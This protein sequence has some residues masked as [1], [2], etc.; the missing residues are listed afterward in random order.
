MRVLS[1]LDRVVRRP[2]RRAVVTIG[3]FDGVHVAHQQLIRRTVAAARRVHGTSVVITFNPDPQHVLHPAGAFRA[4]MP[5]AERLRHLEALGVAWIWVIPFTRRFARLSAA[6]F[7]T[8]FLLRRLRPLL[9]IAGSDFAFGQS[10]RGSM[11]VLRALGASQGVRV[12]AVPPIRR[13][14]RPVSSSRIRRLIEAGRLEDARALLGR[15]PALYGR[16]VRGAGRGRRL[17]MP[18]A[19][20]RL[21]PQV[22]PPR[23]VYAVWV[24]DGHRR[25]RGVMNLGVR[26]TFGPGPLVCEV[27][28]IGFS[29]SLSQRSLIVRLVRRL[30]SERRFASATALQ[31]QVRRDRRLALR[32]LA[33]S[34]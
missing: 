25:W 32:A 2:P 4:L 17:G 33:R 8:R 30:R 18:T 15:P 21:I 14:G 12:D 29:G 19:N 23:G 31:R 24:E 11:A 22:T 5:L 13:L 3:V 1:G 9:I 10:R 7:V 26:P 34:T 20:L 27:H 6:T 16:V 28:L